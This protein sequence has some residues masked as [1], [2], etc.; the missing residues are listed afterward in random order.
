MVDVRQCNGELIHWDNFSAVTYSTGTIVACDD[1]YPFGQ[2]MDGRSKLIGQPDARYKFTGKERDQE[3][4]WDYFG[5][6]YYDSRI[7]RWL[8]VDPLAH[9]NPNLSPYVY[10]ANNP[11][12]YI[13]VD[14]R[15]YGVTI[16][17]NK[18]TIT[19]SATYYVSDDASKEA[20]DEGAAEWNAYKGTYTTGDGEEYSISFELSV[21]QVAESWQPESAMGSDP[22]PNQLEVSQKDFEAAAKSS[23]S[24]DGTAGITTYERM[25]V[26]EIPCQNMELMRTPLPMRLVTLCFRSMAEML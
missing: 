10:C 21:V 23:K 17:H 26:A 2:L 8:S 5:A 24:P 19:I 12:K 20:A 6:R 16:D 14:G 15:N 11:F 7:G 9:I 13:E 18:K 3:T 1:F 25:G 22:T 4:G